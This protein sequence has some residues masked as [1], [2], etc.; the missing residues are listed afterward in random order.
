M[1]KGF[2]LIEVVA[3]ILVLAGIFL[4]SFPLFTNM[5]KVDEEKL[6]DDMVDN[7]CV[8]GKTFMY[9]NLDDFPE[10][11]IAHSELEIPISELIIYGNVD[12]DVVNP[13]TKLSVDVDKLKYTVLDDLSLKCEYIEELRD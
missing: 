7:L 5:A 8:A 6:Y 3:I 4:I 13:K 2:T 10:L 9:S 1:N 12:E 11:S